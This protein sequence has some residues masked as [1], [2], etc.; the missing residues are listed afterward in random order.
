MQAESAAPVCVVVGPLC[1][2]TVT[3]E[4]DDQ[5]QRVHLHPGGQGFWIA[6]MIQALGATPVLVSP[7]GG[8]A[9]LVLTHLIP[10]WGV[11]FRGVQMSGASPTQVHDRSSEVRVE[12]VAIS[13][14]ALDRHEQDDL[15]G[16][17]LEAALSADAAVITAS[18][19]GT[20]LPDHSYQRLVADLRS[21][22]VAV[23]GD[24]HGDAL[25]A[26]LADDNADELPSFD[27][28]KVSEDDLIADGWSI[29]S[30]LD[31]IRA[32]QR[33]QQRTG[34]AVVVSRAGD[35]AIAAV[36]GRVVRVIPPE[37]SVVDHRGA[38]DSMTG[39]IVAGRVQGLDHLSAIRLGAAA[40]AGNVT[41]HGLGTGN[42]G[43]ID[44]LVDLV[45]IEDV[46]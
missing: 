1:F 40:G 41:R 19:E 34:G 31:S 28:L 16:A 30:E 46:T 29:Q 24:L 4:S 6:R 43:L 44:E 37:L 15:Y 23:F 2:L 42:P 3:I 12:L 20:V 25:R 27:T 17:V 18:I 32:A 26:A 5:P 45:A 10:T 9:G 33:L 35:P 39:A 13:E 22:D 14:P 11:T 21:R 8:E 36:D 7:V 38:G